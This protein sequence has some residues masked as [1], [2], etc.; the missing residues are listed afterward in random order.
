MKGELYFLK[1]RTGLIPDILSVES[2]RRL[3]DETLFEY[4]M[5]RSLYIKTFVTCYGKSVSYTLKLQRKS[6]LFLS[7]DLSTHINSVGMSICLFR[8]KKYTS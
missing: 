4:Y 2:K 5:S 7:F 3:I 6:S 1:K 8:L